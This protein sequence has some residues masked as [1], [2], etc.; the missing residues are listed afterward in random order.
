MAGRVNEEGLKI[1]DDGNVFEIYQDLFWEYDELNSRIE[2]KGY[3]ED[4]RCRATHGFTIIYYKKI[5]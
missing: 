1:D 3:V 5:E 4:K 2:A